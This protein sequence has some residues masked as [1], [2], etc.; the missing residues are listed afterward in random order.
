[1]A[2]Q[3]RSDI[4]NRSLTISCLKKMYSNGFEAVKDIN[5]KMFAD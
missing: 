2:E 1:M 5:L 3:A 4:Q